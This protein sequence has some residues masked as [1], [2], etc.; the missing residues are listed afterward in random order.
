MKTTIRSLLMTFAIVGGSVLL[1]AG[2]NCDAYF[3]MKKGSTREMKSYDKKDKLTGTSRQKVLDIQDIPGG[4]KITV[5]SESF[6]D[7]DKPVGSMDMGMK[8]ENGIFT[9]D[10]RNYV[11]PS[12]MAGMQGMEVKMDASD[13][14][15]PSHLAAGQQLKDGYVHMTA[16]NMGMT[17]MNLE[18]KIL[19]RKVE[20]IENITTPAGTFSCVKLTYDTEVKLMGK[21][22]AKGIEWFAK[23]VGS[24]RSE[25]YDKSGKLLTYSVLTAM[26]N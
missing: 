11:D 18:I 10:M 1:V 6:D 9:I 14:E 15:M 4:M 17:I 25:T 13:L 12:T 22:T 21:T 26:S 7:K 2:Q 16:S 3:P 20:A 23:D 5:H 24:V 8:C 19:N